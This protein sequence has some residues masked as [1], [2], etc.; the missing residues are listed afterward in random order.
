MICRSAKT[1]RDQICC[2]SPPR[3]NCYRDRAGSLVL[4]DWNWIDESFEKDWF[5]GLFV[6]KSSFLG[7]AVSKIWRENPFVRGPKMKLNQR[8]CSKPKNRLFRCNELGQP[9]VQRWSPQEWECR[10][11]CE[12][13]SKIVYCRVCNWDKV[14]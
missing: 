14:L 1:E 9:F 12:V 13:H 3:V 11:P 4:E 8:S 5:Q 10:A 7:M 2:W 6:P